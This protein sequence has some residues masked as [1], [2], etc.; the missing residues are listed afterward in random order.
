MQKTSSSLGKTQC[1]GLAT[2]RACL[3]TKEDRVIPSGT[4][5][6]KRLSESGKIP[7]HSGRE[8]V[9]VILRK[10]YEGLPE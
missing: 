10:S 2:L 4:R 7:D 6:R 8:E 5:L 1:D 9:V 3:R